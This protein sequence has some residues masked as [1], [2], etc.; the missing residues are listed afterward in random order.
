MKEQIEGRHALVTGAAQG[1]GAATAARLR[2]AGAR[3]SL[4][5]RRAIA[6][7]DAI[8]CDLS[9]PEEVEKAVADAR[10]RHG[11]I[12]ILINNAGVMLPGDFDERG[13]ADWEKTLEV[14]LRG[15]LRLTHALLPSMLERDRGVIVNV[16]SAS[17]TIGVPGIAV[18]SASK[19]A[20]WGFTESLIG[21]LR[22]RG[23]RVHVAAVLPNFI[24]TGLFEGAHLTGLGKLIVPRVK[25]HDVIARAIVEKAIKK[26]KM[27][28]M[29]P[30]TV[31]LA[32]LFRGLLPYRIFVALSRGL[33]AAGS[34][35]HLKPNRDPED[36]Q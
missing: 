25:S 27:L 28:I 19:W 20:L 3:L 7:E 9:S 18:Y 34:M 4:L 16:V 31:R 8:E 1:I 21:E 36:K 24:R 15:A 6:D 33:G 2:K 26:R 17:A 23:S 35:Q 30:V 13:M 10:K 29:R 22:N 12:D 5:D 32:L 14:N 11:P